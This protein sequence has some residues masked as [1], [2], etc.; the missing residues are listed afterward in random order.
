MITRL[1]NKI[2]RMI[3]G[4]KER[5]KP[6]FLIIGGQKCGTTALYDYLAR[7]PNVS[8]PEV[9]EL[10]FFNCVG[11][12]SKGPSFYHSLFPFDDGNGQK[13]TFE[14][15]P[16]YMVSPFAAERIFEYRNDIKFLVMLREPAE[17]AFS[18]WN[19][20]RKFY[21]EN[22]EWLK[23]WIERCES[24][25]KEFGNSYYGASLAR[26]NLEKFDDF[27]YVVN[28]EIDALSEKK[29]I[30]APVILQGMYTV[31][32]E[33]YLSLFDKSQFNFF[34]NRWLK[35]DTV[36]L[37]SEVERFVGLPPYDWSK[38][39]FNP[40]LKG[41]YEG[42]IPVRTLERLKEFYAPLNERLFDILESRFDW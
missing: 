13:T 15:S 26:R 18:G 41:E 8:A 2:G 34:E 20:Y 32:I 27:D 11:R 33:R 39:I 3:E 24:N 12:Y 1:K 6:S 4:R 9:K 40:V 25:F 28:E 16:G 31:Q 38:E 37:L 10:D 7:H 23:D 21:R 14:A 22:K 17:R 5:L 19:M 29:V 42:C 30:E 36:T 35:T